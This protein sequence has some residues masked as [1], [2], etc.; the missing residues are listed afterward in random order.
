MH[1]VQ[2]NG[3]R[4]AQHESDGKRLDGLADAPLT[5]AHPPGALH[6]LPQDL[7]TPRL[8]KKVSMFETAPTLQYL[9][10]DAIKMIFVSCF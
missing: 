1:R 2:S 5:R 3:A 7:P 9:I 6:T 10:S 4:L 8:K